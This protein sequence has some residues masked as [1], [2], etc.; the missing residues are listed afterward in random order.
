M[1]ERWISEQCA[2]LEDLERNDI[3][4]MYSKIKNM[5]KKTSRPANTALKR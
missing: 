3:Q 4:M 5:S 1:K 2:E